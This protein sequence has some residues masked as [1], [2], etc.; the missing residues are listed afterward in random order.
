V[1]GAV[2]ARRTRP[3]LT[4]ALAA[5]CI[6]V[7]G[8]LA[9]APA[10]AFRGHAFGFTFGS[11]SSGTVDPEPLSAPS[12]VAVNEASGQIY[13]LDQG[14]ARIERFGSTGVY[15][16]QFA[17]PSATGTGTLESG[18]ETITVTN[19]STGS[20]AVGEEVSALGLPPETTITAVSGTTLKISKPATASE[21]AALTAHYIFAF[22]GEALSGGIAVDNSCVLRKLSGSACSTSDP[23]N[24]DVYVTDPGHSV[25]DKFDAQGNYLGQLDNSSGAAFNFNSLAGVGVDPLGT[26][27]VYYDG[28]HV[29]GDVAS[30]TNADQSIPTTAIPPTR[31]L[32][33]EPCVGFSLPGFAVDSKDNLYTRK[34]GL[35]APAV[36]P[37]FDSSGHLV[38]CLVGSEEDTSAVALDLVSDEVFLD[39]VTSV[40]AFSSG[41]ALQERFGEGHLG[42]GSGV[43]VNH[44][45]GTAYA[46]DVAVDVVDVFPPE[47]PGAPVVQEPSQAVF[48]VNAEGA[49]F[50]A[51]VNPRGEAGEAPTKFQFE[52]GRCLTP[53]TC[54]ESA[55]ES[56]VPVPDG[57][58]SP[59]FETHIATARAR[60]LSPGT[61]YHVRVFVH[62][63]RGEAHGEEAIF[64][65]QSAG[66]LT[67]PD[68]RS[69]EMVSP[70]NKHGAL[71]SR[72][73]EG[74]LTQAAAGGAAIT[75]VTDAPTEAQPEGYATTMQVLALRG[76]DGWTSRDIGA[77][78]EVATGLG[79]AG[80][81]YRF[82]SES[83]AFGVLQPF[84]G[85]N[86]TLSPDASEQA[87]Y[88]RTDFIEGDGFCEK[89]CYRPLVTGENVEAG[90]EFGEEGLCPPHSLCG[91]RF[92]G[93]SDDAHHVV[94]SSDIPLSSAATAGSL[95]EW[96]EGQLSLI[97]VLPDGESGGAVSA[98]LG[99]Q[100]QNARGAISRDGNRVVWTKQG[101]VSHL[102]LRDIGREQTIKLDTVE[103]GAGANEPRPVFQLASADGSRVLFSDN[104]RLTKDSKAGNG[105]Q[106]ADLYECDI[107]EEEG[108]ELG[109][110]LSDLTPGGKLQGVV[111]GASA[112]LGS[113]YFVARGALAPGAV[114]GKPNLYLHRNNE[115]VLVAT[116]ADEDSPD[117][118]HGT[119]ADLEDLTVR[120]SG[121]G[122]WLAF[123]SARPLSGYDNRDAISGHSDEEVFLY[124]ASRPVGAGNPACVSCDPTGARPVGSEYIKLGF[125]ENQT[126]LVGG[127][128]VWPPS[129][130]LAANVPGG[131][132]YLAGHALHQSR[133]L[134]DDGRMFFNSADAL[135]PQDVNG[136]WDVYEYEPPGVGNCGSASSTFSERS[137]GCVDLVSS[138]ASP[139]ESAF[140]DASE[141]GSDVFFLTAAK[142]VPE[143][144]D[145]SLDV[146]DAHECTSS[147]PCIAQAAPEPPPCTSDA[148]CRAAPTRQPDV[149]GAPPSA[150]FSGIGNHV[151]A[152]AVKPPNKA[153]KLAKALSACRKL[154]KTS[155]KRRVAC[156]RKDRKR[157]RGRAASKPKGRR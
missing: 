9:A 138:G 3:G 31:Q 134:A 113:V 154:H 156:E 106:E 115:T 97:S 67:L 101:G 25:V 60:G 39:N 112:D 120:V 23:S 74:R 1:G 146:Y 29:S 95:Y 119:S 133:Y 102:Y 107:V 21:S 72:I 8:G 33:N 49:S 56:S 151:P 30:F 50:S 52:Y 46:A 150:L 22:G 63:A 145:T 43:A 54:G 130:W 90:V 84:G 36:V 99:F 59:D 58:L 20:F 76:G 136:T 27:W 16:T 147:S 55:F 132:S 75:Y 111:S 69:W 19:V 66:T 62:N 81:E 15:E 98:A 87:P 139:E 57:K 61:V 109:C 100:G 47:P 6:F 123:M 51:E 142:L 71:V 79:L 68:E 121:D 131:T 44:A 7:W 93:A 143:D 155:R 28:G 82:F 37:K 116:L 105:E 85:F 125:G 53:A 94:L 128:G 141:T 149:F 126:S 40:G 78:H 129:A 117:W 114:A 24:G 48:N 42:S 45:T 153:Q 89:A 144:F 118:A 41:A 110:H 86:P 17:G 122:R 103:L 77:P 14:N 65:T 104:Q 96:S 11:G 157:Y 137:G 152:P 34:T 5:L 92:V 18:S 108:G 12:A 64:T 26:V 38:S 73:A 10:L 88:L 124:D 127:T 140:L 148:S 70:P 32:R 13:V 135:V 80:G 2:R 4:A 35:S 91:P 83:L